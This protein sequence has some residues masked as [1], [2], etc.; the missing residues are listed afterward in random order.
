M[1]IPHGKIL[2]PGP[3][4]KEAP[5]S[6]AEIGEFLDSLARS[7][8][9]T[10]LERTDDG[11]AFN[12]IRA[13][14]AERRPRPATR[15]SGSVPWAPA[16]NDIMREV[17]D[18]VDKGA[19][20]H[21]RIRWLV[22]TALGFPPTLATREHA[23]DS[24]DK[25]LSACLIALRGLGYTRHDGASIS[26][27][28]AGRSRIESGLPFKGEELPARYRGESARR[29]LVLQEHAGRL[30]AA[31][32]DMEPDQLVRLWRNA[33]RILSDTSR[34]AEHRLASDVVAAVESAWDALEIA[35]DELFAWSSTE[36]GSRSGASQVPGFRSEGMLSYLEYRVGK[37]AGNP[38][39][40]RQSILAR[41]FEGKLPRVFEPSHMDEWGIPGSARRLRKMAESLAAFARNFKRQDE[42]RYDEAIRQWEQDLEFLHDRYYVGRFGFGWPST[43]VHGP[44]ALPRRGTSRRGNQPGLASVPAQAGATIR[45]IQEARMELV[46][47]KGAGRVCSLMRRDRYLQSSVIPCAFLSPG[48]PA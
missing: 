19:T 27:L 37:E 18:A 7:G 9:V 16:I 10:A 2:A 42:D 35:E 12:V 31:I 22:A 40:V 23:G 4:G 20:R 30:A 47:F 41:V 3:D 33:N 15:P 32:P 46:S 28:P 1:R 48:L 8:K 24:L 29:R 39:A 13:R 34:F 17:L 26:I 45:R 43:S 36:V 38:A 25:R 6:M 11:F 14:P 5:V 44:E 21:A